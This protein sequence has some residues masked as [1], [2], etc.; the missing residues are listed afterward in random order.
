MDHG[1]WLVEGLCVYVASFSGGCQGGGAG[2]DMVN[3]HSNMR[4]FMYAFIYGE[5]NYG[6]R[7]AML[8]QF[9]GE[10]A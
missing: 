1:C 3:S 9:W 6:C 4:V 10:E 2:G 8:L 5:S 7:E